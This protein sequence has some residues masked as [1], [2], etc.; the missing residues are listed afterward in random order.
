MKEY[1]S[2]IQ[3]IVGKYSLVSG[4]VTDNEID[5]LRTRLEELMKVKNISPC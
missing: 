3:H 5:Y 1:H 2:S 4:D